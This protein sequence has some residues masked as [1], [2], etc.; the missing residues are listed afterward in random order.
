[1]LLLKKLIPENDMGLRG[2]AEFVL[3]GGHVLLAPGFY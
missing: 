1:M 3:A 2:R